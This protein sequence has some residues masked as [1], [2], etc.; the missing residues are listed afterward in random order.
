MDPAGPAAQPVDQ[1]AQQAGDRISGEEHS[2]QGCG[3]ADGVKGG[4]NGRIEDAAGEASDRAQ[5]E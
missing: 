2:R 5:D 4:R 3:G 1:T